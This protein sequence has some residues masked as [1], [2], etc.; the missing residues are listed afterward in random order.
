MKKYTFNVE[1]MSCEHCVAA[2]MSAVEGVAGVV[3]KT[4]V[5]DT[6]LLTVTSDSDIK[7]DVIDAVYDQGYDVTFLGCVD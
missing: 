5:L 2:V 4:L 3:D 1:G 6:K 7:Q